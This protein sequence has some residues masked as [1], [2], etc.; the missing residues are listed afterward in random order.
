MRSLGAGHVVGSTIPDWLETIRV[1]IWPVVLLVVVLL[2]V[3]TKRG[4]RFFQQS[5][6]QVKAFGIEVVLDA[7]TAREVQV[8]AEKLFSDFRAEIRLYLERVNARDKLASRLQTVVT[9]SL[10]PFLD[11]AGLPTEGREDLRC[12]VYV[13]DA[14]FKG[15]LCQLIDYID[16][17]GQQAGGGHGR[18][19]TTRFG[20]IGI[21]WRLGTQDV[22]GTVPTTPEELIRHW[23]MTRAQAKAAGRG[24]KSFVAVVL[25]DDT[26][27]PVGLVY[28][29]A[30]EENLFGDD[31]TVGLLAAQVRQG[32]RD[33][34][35]TERLSLLQVAFIDRAPRIALTSDDA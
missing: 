16:S 1:V 27:V 28:A 22:A 15:T 2:L 8:G 32:A 21:A 3:L 29:D 6:R 26:D 13:P 20:M 7:E 12:T 25:T 33:T 30:F 9:G 17:T 19:F 23:G 5:V 34:G 4:R 31:A 10:I 24:R 14:L 11:G 18:V 35:L